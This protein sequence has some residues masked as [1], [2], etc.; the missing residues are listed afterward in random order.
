MNCLESVERKK[1]GYFY[2][3]VREYRHRLKVA[4]KRAIQIG[5]IVAF[6]TALIDNPTSSGRHQ[7][8]VAECKLCSTVLHGMVSVTDRAVELWHVFSAF[9]G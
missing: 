2:V 9:S 1:A 6:C 7:S 3:D 4:G 5:N 8:T